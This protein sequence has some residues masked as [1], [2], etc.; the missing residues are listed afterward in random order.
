MRFQKVLLVCALLAGCGE[1]EVDVLSLPSERGKGRTIMVI[2]DGIDL[3]HQVFAGRVAAKYTIDCDEVLPSGGSAETIR[4]NAIAALESGEL[5]CRITEGLELKKSPEFAEITQYRETWN[6]AVMAKDLGALERVLDL[7]TLSK[8]SRILAG[9]DSE[10][11]EAFSYHG[12]ATAGL[13]AYLSP[14]IRLVTVQM[15][16][17]PPEDEEAATEEEAEA[18]CP[19]VAEMATEVEVL[20]HPDFQAAYL[21][22]GSNTFD[23][24]LE[25]VIARHGVSLVNF[26][27][28]RYPYA[29]IIQAL[30]EMACPLDLAEMLRLM[31]E[32]D[33]II[34]QL[35][36]KR[37]D[38]TPPP[39]YLFVQAAGNDGARI[40]SPDDAPD[41]FPI[42][43]QKV[44]VGAFTHSQLVS[45]FSN[46]GECVRYFTMGDEVTVAIPD[47]FLGTASGTSFAAPLLVRHIALAFPAA[48]TP[49]DII[50]GLD[51]ERDAR[52]FLPTDTFPEEL[53]A[54][55]EK[56]RISSYALKGFDARKIIRRFQLQ[57]RMG[58]A[59]S[60]L[61]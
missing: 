14:H 1:H 28:G 37:L 26:S 41:C 39:D 51:R 54:T 53:V 34:G 31:R 57:R 45:N 43:R 36:Q 42:P 19:N 47:G 40:D 32:R 60:S 15:N 38:A 7:N 20:R 13:I 16:F 22:N 48:A 29:V 11:N 44:L 12:T 27:A 55:N 59:F 23:A 58:W 2:D 10:G 56:S 25:T 9:Y 61:L 6:Q 3:S 5:G 8:I 21:A 18:S 52:K 46:S 17:G 30:K 50:A 49:A 24:Q 35:N 4:A 33:A